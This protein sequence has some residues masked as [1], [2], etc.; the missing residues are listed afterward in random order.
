MIRGKSVTGDKR[1]SRR[2]PLLVIVVVAGVL[3]VLVL[4][5]RHCRSELGAARY[6]VGGQVLVAGSAGDVDAVMDNVRQ[7]LD[8]DEETLQRRERLELDFLDELPDTCR[9]LPEAGASF[10]IDQYQVVD[11]VSVAQVIEEIQQQAEVL[12]VAVSPE[13]NYLTG[14][15][16]TDVTGDPWSVGADPWSVGADPSADLAA[17]AHQAFRDQWA[18]GGN[19]INLKAVM[20]RGWSRGH[21]VRVGI[22]DTSPFPISVQHVVFSMEPPLELMLVHPVP[23]GQMNPEEEAPDVSDHG[24][25][26]AGLVHA[27]A[28]GSE[29]QLIRVLDDTGQGDLQTLNRSLKVFINETLAERDRLKGAVINL[30]LGVHPPPD[31]E[32]KGLPEDI[33]SLN[34]LLSAAR[35]HGIIV[36]ASSGNDSADSQTPLPMQIPARWDSTL[37]VSASNIDRDLACFSNVGE[38]SAPGG[39]GGPAPPSCE[40]VLHTCTGDCPY[41]LISLSSAFNTG[42][43]YWNGTSFSA[44][45]VSG[46][47]A[48]IIDTEGAWPHP[49]VVF[50]TLRSSAAASQGVVDA[51]RCPP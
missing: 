3:L 8:L 49:D 32:E 33:T 40:Q 14:R 5:L 35:C 12:K 27:V 48:V 31:A 23:G 7:I 11:D 21:G 50:E 22:F 34:V 16:P 41:G 1:S 2:W 6:Y 28:P 45:L 46:L 15:P 42:Y 30:S 17:L 51:Q 19:G 47:A 37:G 39:D 13:P 18:F 43:A 9:G 44:P 10:V 36:V 25:F 29:I 24:L 4:V 20:Q 26:A 38:V